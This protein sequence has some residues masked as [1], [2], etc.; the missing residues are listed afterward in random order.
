VSAGVCIRLYD[1]AEFA[2]REPFTAPEI[3][4]TNLASVILQMKAL[5]LG[6]IQDFPFVE[7]PD[8]RMIK[9]GLQTLHELGAVDENNELTDLGRQ[10]SRLP[11]DPRLARMILEAGRE[12]CLDEVLVIVAALSIQDPRERPLDKQQAADAAHA[13]FR[14]E[15][16]DFLGLLKMW[17]WY[18]EHAKQLSHNKLRKLCRENFISFIRMRE[19][20]D[21]HQQLRALAFEL[22]QR[23]RPSIHRHPRRQ[24]R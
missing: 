3:V 2:A 19:W 22:P 23:Q 4:R 8:Y 1:E 21:V 11:I 9:D 14:D 24:R 13:K 6:D 15:R 10:M 20:D 5:R 17:K 18:R 7:P 12:K 16:S